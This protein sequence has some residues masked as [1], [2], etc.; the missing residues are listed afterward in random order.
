MA[1]LFPDSCAGDNRSPLDLTMLML[2]EE[3]LHRVSRQLSDRIKEQRGQLANELL[4]A[5]AGGVQ[6]RLGADAALAAEAA[7]AEDLAADVGDGEEGC[8]TLSRLT[9]AQH[10]LAAVQDA[11]K[12]I[13]EGAYGWCKQ[14]GSPIARDRLL[15]Q[16]YVCLCEGCQGK[17][18]RAGVH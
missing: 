14:C 2:L 12:R 7:T 15:A 5:L 17:V 8:D 9:R 10:E 4:P 13:R 3:R 11:L 18:R 1:T 16:P 6:V